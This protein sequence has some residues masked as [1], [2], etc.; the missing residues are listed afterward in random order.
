MS[1]TEGTA[2]RTG[3]W[4]RLGWRVVR[5]PDPR[6]AYVLGAVAGA[7]ATIAVLALVVELTSDD[8]TAPGV[9]LDGALL[10]GAVFVG[11]RWRGPVRSAAVAATVLAV[12]ALWFFALAGDGITSA[13]DLRGVYVLTTL[14]YGGLYL[15]GWTRGR[16]ILLGALLVF[17]SIW[18][19]SEVS[20]GPVGTVPFQTE[21]DSSTIFPD[22]PFS[23]D[24]PA[25]GPDSDTDG[26]PSPV[27]DAEDESST[28]T[29]VTSLI[30]GAV[31]LG[32]AVV[33][34]RR[35]RPGAATPFVV[36]GVVL[37]IVGALVLGIEEGA[38][39]GG[40][41]GILAG[42]AIAATGALA[43]RRA[44]VWI[45]VLTIFVGIVVLVV[46]IAGEDS[47]LAVAGT[48][49]GFALVVGVAA[50]L[51]ADRIGEPDD[52]PPA[53]RRSVVF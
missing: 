29:A 47:A 42:A 32:A 26:V 1:S 38:T 33:L 53:A 43:S 25:V 46:K 8:A 51:L 20:S 28:D 5:R 41:F 50:V 7:L 4:D 9:V 13:G 16:A 52:D 31:F 49:A 36:V 35:G 22:T 39:V 27:F 19:L 17:V 44:S 24:V 30:L 23:D 34:D 45:G 18:V 37:A 6:V 48:A 40:V 12:P 14:T 3:F 10:V 2:P 15:F 21:I 11:A